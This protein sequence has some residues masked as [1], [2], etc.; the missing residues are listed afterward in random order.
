MLAKISLSD[1]AK[2]YVSLHLTFS[3]LSLGLLAFGVFFAWSGL[4]YRAGLLA[5][6]GSIIETL[7]LVSSNI[8]GFTLPL[9]GILACILGIASSAASTILG[10]SI[11]S[12]KIRREPFILP[13]QI[14][15]TSVLSALTAVITI[16][17]GSLVPSPTGGY[18]HIG[19][20]VIF[21]AAMLFGSKV[22]GLTGIIGS[23]VADFWLA[24]PRWYVSIPAHGLEGAIAGFGKNKPLAIQVIL[25][26]F[27][28]FIMASTYFYVNLFIKG[29]PLAL[30]SY[31]RDLFGQA[32]VSL[33]LAIGI[34]KTVKKIGLCPR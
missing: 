15:V 33:L 31:A 34:S 1:Q 7:P 12:V 13:Y 11:S 19:D 22:G 21:V 24:Y 5:A 30:I 9:S 32:G 26:I 29:Y 16:I 2:M 8:F 23:V 20:M 3:S 14:A 27:A 10:F 17:T 4:T 6:F 25:C 18:T 28:G